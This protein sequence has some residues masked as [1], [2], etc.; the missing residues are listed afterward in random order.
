MPHNP[1]PLTTAVVSL[2]V[3]ASTAISPAGVTISEFKADSSEY[4]LRSTP[5]GIKTVGSG[6]P[7]FS[8]QFDD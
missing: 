5:T 4:L 7:W 6:A 8:T 2:A 1:L 3:L